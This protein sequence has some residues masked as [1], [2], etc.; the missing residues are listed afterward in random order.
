MGKSARHMLVLFGNL[1]ARSGVRCAPT[2]GDLC[3]F[4]CAL[5]QYPSDP[6]GQPWCVPHW[7]TDALSANWP[8]RLAVAALPSQLLAVS[9]ELVVVTVVENSNPVSKLYELVVCVDKLHSVVP[10]ELNDWVLVVE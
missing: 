3:G 1:G 2:S 7:A 8:K 5:N 4:A 9:T 6:I 10:L